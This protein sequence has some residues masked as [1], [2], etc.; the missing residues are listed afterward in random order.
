[1]LFS[2]LIQYGNCSPAFTPEE[3]T[4]QSLDPATKEQDQP[5]ATLSQKQP[6]FFASYFNCGE[7][8]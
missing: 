3:S 7:S 4:Y 5:Y 2:F 1:M 8:Y 6:P